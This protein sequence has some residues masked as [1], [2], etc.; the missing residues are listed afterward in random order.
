M[1][2]ARHSE[3]WRVWPSIRAGKRFPWALQ[4]IAMS[5]LPTKFQTNGK[6]GRRAV[7]AALKALRWGTMRCVHLP[8][9]LYIKVMAPLLHVVSLYRTPF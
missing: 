3:L 4:G 6:V 2:D 5:P 9:A 8:N 7:L 1:H